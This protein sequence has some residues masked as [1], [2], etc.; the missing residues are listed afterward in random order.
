MIIN[1]N[2]LTIE[3]LNDLIVTAASVR[4]DKVEAKRQER[5][6]ILNNHWDGIRTLIHQYENNYTVMM[7]VRDNAGHIRHFVMNGDTDVQFE[8]CRL[9]GQREEG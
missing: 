4:A 5:E 3:Q 9:R 8:L 2:D 6:S 7:R 1:V